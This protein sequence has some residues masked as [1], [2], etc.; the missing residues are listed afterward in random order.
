MADLERIPPER[1]RQH[2][3]ANGALLVCAY[4]SKEKCQQ[5]YLTGAISLSELQ[6]RL[7][8]MARNQE[9]IFYCA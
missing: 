6:S 3:A 8:G 7:Q 4:D 9:I 1:A 2:M 5:N